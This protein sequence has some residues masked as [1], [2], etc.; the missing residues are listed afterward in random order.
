MSDEQKGTENVV[1]AFMELTSGIQ[2][3]L[4]RIEELAKEQS[5]AMAKLEARVEALEK[6]S[7]SK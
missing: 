7:V 1:E 3:A 2:Q 6:R 5:Q 4:I